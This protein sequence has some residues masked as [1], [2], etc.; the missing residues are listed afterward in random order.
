M[1]WAGFAAV[2]AAFFL[3]HSIP[4]RPAIKARLV[5]RFGAAG[6]GAGYSLLSVVMLALLIWAA[7]AAPH[8]E[9]WQ[10]QLW[11][12]HAIQLGMLAVCLLLALT[13]GRPNPLS[14]GGAHSEAFDPK[15]AGLIRLVRHPVLLAFA[16]WA[17]LHLLPNGDLAHVILF[18]MLGSFALFG[19]LILDRRKKRMLGAE[20]WATLTKELRRAPLFYKPDAPAAL[21]VRLLV[22]LAVYAALL[23]L[24]PVVIGVSAS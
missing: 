21:F 17:G 1:T 20:R 16:L 5:E 3:T 18:A 15:R 8:V 19:R 10:Q 11:H 23:A 12:R 6:F 4:T 14:F 22:G 7:G 13:L 9:L 24:H 2:F